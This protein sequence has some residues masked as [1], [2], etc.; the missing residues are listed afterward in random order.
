M[1]DIVVILA[2]SLFWACHADAQGRSD[3]ETNNL[4]GAVHKVRIEK[5]P[6]SEEG[7]RHV[8]GP[9][10]SSEVT[11]DQKGNKIEETTYGAG[12][13]LVGRSVFE[14]DTADN[15]T[16]VTV[17]NADGSINL[18]RVRK[19]L[20]VSEG[21]KVEE[22][23]WASGTIFQAMT[24]YNYDNKDRGTELATFDA[25]GK[26]GMRVVTIYG[27][28]GKPT[29]IKTFQRNTLTG[30]VIFSYDAQGNQTG[31]S[32]YDAAG[33]RGSKYVFSGDLTRGSHTEM[34]E[35]DAKDNLVKKESYI[36][37]FDSHGNWIKSISSEWEK[38]TGK[39]RPVEVTKRSITYY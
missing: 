18:K 10:E 39:S 7:N 19:S 1:K 14:Y 8:A 29:E 26:P 20:P 35:Y 5:S 32:E 27:P 6:L 17:Y 4:S 36:R 23:I 3:R 11:Y 33:V 13:S 28:N 37:E 31:N 16:A 34:T 24:I 38:S 15:L 22:S 2:L 21:R 25:N 9:R 30:R 12:N